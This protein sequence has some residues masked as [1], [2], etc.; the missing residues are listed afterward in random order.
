MTSFKA[1][2][3]KFFSVWYVQ[4]LKRHQALPGIANTEK[5][6]L[7]YINYFIAVSISV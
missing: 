1:I 3:L 5:L 2:N 6:I 4:M 7:L